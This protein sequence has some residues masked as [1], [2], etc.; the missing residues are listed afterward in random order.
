MAD[1]FGKG[2]LILI[3]IAIVIFGS[4]KLP[5]AARNLGKS[6]RIFKNELDSGDKDRPSTSDEQ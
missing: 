6:I 5:D 3:L 2:G 4:K 1:L